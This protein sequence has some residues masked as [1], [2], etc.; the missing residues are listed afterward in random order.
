MSEVEL[1]Q[2]PSDGISH[3]RFAHHNSSLLCASSWDKGLYVY[4]A[5]DNLLRHV[6][7]HPSPL[8]TCTFSKDDQRIFAG[9]LDRRVTAVALLTAQQQA[10]ETVGLHDA[11]V[12]CVH[13]IE[14]LVISG[15]WD[16]K[17]RVWDVRTP[18]SSRL[19]GEFALEGKVYAM[20]V[21]GSKIVA[22]D[23][24]GK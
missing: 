10:V 4:S 15:G 3:L 18:K 11:P 16:G 13:A 24:Q 1:S 7:A 9:G 23:H 6:F 5:G 14:D 19:T 8:L 12:K 17:V 2:S 21:A 20:D 22:V